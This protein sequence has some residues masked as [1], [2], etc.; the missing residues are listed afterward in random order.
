M[1]NEHAHHTHPAT[2][3]HHHDMTH[4]DHDAAQMAHPMPMLHDHGHMADD[5]GMAHMDMTDLAKRFWWSLA[6][7]L[8]IILITPLMDMTLPFT[9]QFPGDT[10]VTTILAIALYIIGTPPFF[11]GAKAELKAKKPAMMSLV[12]LSLLVTFWYSIYA[13]LA[14]LFWPTQHVMTFFWEFATLTVIMLLGHRIEMTATMQAGDATAQLQALLPQIAHVQHG[15]HMMDMPVAT[16]EPGMVV[17]V[18]AGEAFPADGIILTGESQVDESLMTGESRLIDKTPG[19]TVVG[20]TINGNGTLSVKVTQAGAQSFVGQLQTTLA[21]SAGTKSQVETRADQV[22]SYLF[23]VALIV[24]IASLLIWLPIHGLSYA[25]NVAVTVLVIACPHALGLAVPL[26]IQRTKALAAAQGILIKNHKALSAANHLRYILMDKT[27]TLTT[28]QFKVTQLVTDNFDRAQALGI[29]AALDAQS[30]HPLAQGILNYAKQQQ[31][32]VMTAT[33]VENMAGYGVAG[34]VAGAH[35]RLVSARYLTDQ[36]L[37]YTPL[38][39]EGTISYLLQHEHVVAAVAQ[40]DAI[41]PT[42]PVFINYL[43]AQHLVPVLVTGDN[44]Q[45][46]HA[47]AAELGITAVHAQVSPQEKITLVKTYQK[48]G[49]VMMIGDGINDAPALAQADLSVAIGAG[50]QVAQA[51]ADTVL[52]TNQLPTIID[53]L[54]L[55]KRANKKQIENLWWGAGYNLL[56]LPLAAGALASFGLMLNPM[57][58]AILMSLST[59]IVAL[60]AMT[61]KAS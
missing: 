17:Q 34:M 59:V 21:A 3:A 31:A 55:T 38:Q 60:N 1:T 26:V 30:T 35:F 25:I 5:P 61:L 39:A 29:M 9:I 43:K 7:M 45:V 57:V 14:Q 47:V 37:T 58:G 12:S 8:P 33:Q 23:W 50:T 13:L 11:N 49:A 16:L 40:G 18:L 20:G 6:L 15:D 27:G 10:W 28:G 42:A 24:A 41:K 46:A 51:A 32:P 44:H 19:R 52:V 2:P 56:A 22:A 36:Q 54:K 53:F 4:H 48:Q